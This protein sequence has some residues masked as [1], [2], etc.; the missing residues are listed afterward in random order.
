MFDLS[1]DHTAG[2]SKDRTS[3]FDGQIFRLSQETG[4]KLKEWLDSGIDVE[5]MNRM[6]KRYLDK[7]GG[8]A[9]QT[10]AE[11]LRI[12]EGRVS[13]EWTQ[14]DLSRLERMLEA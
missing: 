8:N 5:R 7:F 14:D 1:A 11:M 10:M 6:Y 2:V 13:R 12:T 9:E 4:H 3:L